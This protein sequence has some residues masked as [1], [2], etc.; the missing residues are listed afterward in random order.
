M[1]MKAVTLYPFVFVCTRVRR[2]VISPCGVVN[3]KT[4]KVGASLALLGS[5]CDRSSQ[6]FHEN[7]SKAAAEP[8]V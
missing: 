2:T 7:H 1:D 6:N 8:T 4:G 3:N 5:L